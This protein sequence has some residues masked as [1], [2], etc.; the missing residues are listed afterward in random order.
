MIALS[1]GDRQSSRQRTG[2]YHR[3]TSWE[4]SALRR[5]SMP[6]PRR[7]MA[8]LLVCLAVLLCES[9][10]AHAEDGYDLWLRYRPVEAPW[11]ERYRTAARELVASTAA[12][13]A[14][15]QELARAIAGLLGTNPPIVK[16]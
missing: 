8:A 6:V 3:C 2:C 15:Q 10:G 11:L 13:E 1:I 14:A 12:G 16:N 5:P 4:K 9:S 7:P